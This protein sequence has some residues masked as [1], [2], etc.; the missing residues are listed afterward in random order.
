MQKGKLNFGGAQF[1]GEVSPGNL[2]RIDAR[3]FEPGASEIYSPQIGLTKIRLAKIQSI[4]F[5][6]S[7]IEPSQIASRE[8]DRLASR[9]LHIEFLDA[10]FAE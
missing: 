3:S 5:Q 9:P 2:G 4:R 7:Q 6:S 10:A 8:V 1:Y